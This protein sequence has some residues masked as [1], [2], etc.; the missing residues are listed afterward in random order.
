MEIAIDLSHYL[1]VSSMDIRLDAAVRADCDV[2]L[3]QIDLSFNPALH[4]QI[5]AAREIA[6]DLDRRTDQSPVLG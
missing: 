1:N 2:V 3:I 5:L 6:I 4:D